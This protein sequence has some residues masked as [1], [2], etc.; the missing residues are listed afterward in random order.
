MTL[1]LPN[2]TSVSKTKYFEYLAINLSYHKTSSKTYWSILKTFV[3]GIM[4]RIIL[5]LLEN[6]KLITDFK[7]KANLFNYFLIN[8]LLHYIIQVQFLKT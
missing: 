7:L 8:N 2:A 3:N 4:I 5:L 1:E 6:N